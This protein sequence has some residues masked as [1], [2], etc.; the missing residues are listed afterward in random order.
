MS[1]PDFVQRAIENLVTSFVREL[2]AALKKDELADWLSNL[3]AQV[4]SLDEHFRS[5]LRKKLQNLS[6]RPNAESTQPST[7]D[8][9]PFQESESTSIDLLAATASFRPAERIQPADEDDHHVRKHDSD[10]SRYD[11]VPPGYRILSQ[12][13]RGGMGIVFKAEHLQLKRQVAMKMILSGSHATANQNARFRAEAQAAAQ[14]KHPNIVQ[15]YS[16]GEHC[17]VPYFELEYVDGVSM[18]QMLKNS[19]MTDRQAS[20]LMLHVSRAVHYSHENK[21]LHRDLKPQNILIAK[22]GTPKVADFGLAKRL[23]EDGLT[24]TGEILGTA[25]YMPPEQARGESTVGPRSDVYSL[26]A[27]LYCMLTGRP[28]F[29]GASQVEIIRQVLASDPVPPSRLQPGLSKDLETICLKCLE[30]EPERRYQSAADLADEFERVNQ[31]KPIVARPITTRERVWKWC[32]RNPRVAGLSGLA[33][34]LL[35]VLL[36]G[37]FAAAVVFNLQRTSESTAR[38]LA[39]DKSLAAQKNEAIAIQQAD[40]TGETTHMVLYETNEFFRRNPQFQELRQKLLTLIEPKIEQLYTEHTSNTE[41][42]VWSA[43]AKR[44]AGEIRFYRGEFEAALKLF[45][46]SEAIAQE[47][48][49]KGE[50]SRPHLNFGTLDLWIGDSL[51]KFGKKGEAKVRFT[52][53]IDH[54]AKHFQTDTTTNPIIV[55]QSMAQAHGRLAGVLVDLEQYRDALQLSQQVVQARRAWYEINKGNLEASEELSGS[56]LQLGIIY[57]HLAQFET[58]KVATEEALS[59]LQRSASN[60]SDHATTYNLANTQKVLGRQLLITGKPNE[61]KENLANSVQNYESAIKLAPAIG[62]ENASEAYYYL[63]CAEMR[64][65]S[66]NAQHCRRGMELIEQSLKNSTSSANRSLKMKFLALL[67]QTDAAEKMAQALVGAAKNAYGCLLGSIGYAL[68]AQHKGVSSEKRK[69][70]LAKAVSLVRQAV[71]LGY[72]D[73][74]TLRHDLDFSPLRELPEFQAILA[75][76]K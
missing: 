13:G 55:Q 46:Q 52:S 21:I 43:N 41:S 56:L 7:D 10:R 76:M 17:D 38:K 37:G 39:D 63:A 53:L 15:V 60:K 18:D 50:L 23:D 59:L 64:L 48:H 65:T 61:A 69:E 44:Q 12:L 34:S 8:T 22:D 35:L 68:A 29:V 70:L 19:V 62:R 2:G 67:G 6:T 49:A 32:Q 74:L 20:E 16:V 42:S 71:E 40:L 4:A 57:E 27:T 28:P 33:A 26:G 58:M 14:L 9:Q 45:L 73:K 3:D 11:A 66:D 51:K 31:G 24:G 30:K 25:A 1:A 75:S 5:S 47:L 36:V 54:R 72:I